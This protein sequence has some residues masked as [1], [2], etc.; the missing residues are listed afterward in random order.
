MGCPTFAKTRFSACCRDID[1]HWEQGDETRSLT[2]LREWKPYLEP[3]PGRIWFNNKHV[4]VGDT[5]L[6]EIYGWIADVG[7]SVRERAGAAGTPIPA[8]EDKLPDR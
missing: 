6:T 5:S 1:E 2:E 7:R 8:P 3:G 4:W